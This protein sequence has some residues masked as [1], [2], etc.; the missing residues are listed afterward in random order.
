MSLVSASGFIGGIKEYGYRGFQELPLVLTLTSLTFVVATGSG[1]H[2]TLLLGFTILIPLLTLGLRGLIK[3]FFSDNTGMKCSNADVCKSVRPYDYTSAHSEAVMIP[4]YWLPSVCFY[5]GYIIA[6][7]YHSYSIYSETSSSI[8]IEKR[9]TKSLQ[10]CIISIILFILILGI[11][12]ALMADCEG[13]GGMAKI[14]SFVFGAILF[15]IGIGTFYLS[16]NCG[17]RSSDLLGV[18]SQMLPEKPKDIRPVVCK[19]S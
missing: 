9:Q 10:I 2:M 6:N 11:R 15:G 14:I 3:L 18:L 5:F 16:N 17:V 1:A 19:A 4:G 13:M 7:S 8:S 12:F